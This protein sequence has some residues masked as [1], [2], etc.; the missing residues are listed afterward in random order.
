MHNRLRSA[1]NSD[2]RS[3][4]WV[5]TDR[6]TGWSLTRTNKKTSSRC[7]LPAYVYVVLSKW[8]RVRFD[9]AL[10]YLAITIAYC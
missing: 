1:I 4:K 7:M 9:V 5:A 10:H 2:L 3:T 6:M 8:G